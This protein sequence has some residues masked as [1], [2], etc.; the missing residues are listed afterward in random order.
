M[1][2]Q[3]ITFLLAG[4][5]AGSITAAAGRVS[6]WV[7]TVGVG[8]VFF[9][10]VLTAIALTGSWAKVR[11][12]FWRYVLAALA[13]TMA[14]VLALLTF[15][16]L[17]GYIQNLLGSRGSTDLSE[18]RLDMWV[19][20]IAAALVAAVCVELM[21]YVLTGRWSNAV[22]VRLAG[23][24]ILAIVLTFVAVRAVR[25]TAT[26]PSLLYYWA[27]F[28]ILFSFGEALFSWLVGSQ[29]WKTSRLPAPAI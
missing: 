28:G 7:L 20:L 2:R 22:L 19:G 29:I 16:W 3:Q 23:A 13:S 1:T 6:L 8:P 11:H 26:L 18:F 10:A 17:G 27:F 12:E 21:A 25:S 24:G 14:Y 5:I 9:L 4:F 15:W